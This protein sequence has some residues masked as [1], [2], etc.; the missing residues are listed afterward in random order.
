MNIVLPFAIAVAC[1]PSAFAQGP[2]AGKAKPA[3]IPF[4]LEGANIVVEAEVAPD[5]RLP[6]VFDSGLS[7]GNIITPEAARSLGLK[8]DSDLDIR[9]A[10]GDLNSAQLTTL[11]KVKI[12]EASFADQ[13]YAILSIP[14]EV[15]ARPG[16]TPLAGFLGA[17]LMEDA[18]LCI[19]Y[20]KQTM[21]RWSRGGFD[22]ANR[23]SIPMNIN[24][25]LPTIEL[26]IDGRRAT[27]VVD[28]GN[29]GGVV[30]YPAFAEANNF[31]KHY[32]NLSTGSGS[33]GGEGFKTLMG[34]ADVVRIGPGAAFGH[35]PLMVIP[36]GMDPTWG[37]DGMVGFE[38]LSRLNPCLDH[39]GERFLFVAE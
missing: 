22:G 24:H 15:T 19:D 36:Q 31:R 28:S 7:H 26:D 38:V 30:V 23:S 14:D 25:G 32:P 5:R 21:Q 35:V 12:G 1:L 3:D 37:I 29:N 9:G 20:K 34:E 2:S 6:F 16:K 8:P 4:T 17:P 13:P 27:L 10:S 18:I 39:D 33:S 11:A